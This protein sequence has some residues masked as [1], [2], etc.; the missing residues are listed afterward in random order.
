MAEAELNKKLKASLQAIRKV[1]N[2]KLYL[3]V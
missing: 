2:I 1:F 3:N